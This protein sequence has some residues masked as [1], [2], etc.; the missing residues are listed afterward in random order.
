MLASCALS[1]DWS[2]LYHARDLE[3]ARARLAKDVDLV[4]AQEIQPFLTSAQ[5]H[6]FSK[7][8]LHFPIADKPSPNPLDCYS[9]QDGRIIL[10]LMT[11]AFIEEMA[12]AYS[13][14]WANHYSSETVDEYL[15]M[16]RNREPGDFPDGR[17][18]TPLEA[19]HIP[20][21]AMNNPAV[22]AMTAR[23]R[24]TTLSFLLLH[25]FGHLSYKT[26]EQ[27]SV[28]RRD[29]VEADEE[30]A[31]DF[32]LEV[33]K[34]NSEPPAGLLMLVHGLL[35]LPAEAGK[36]HPLSTMRLRS[37]ADYLDLRV[38]EFAQG[39]PDGR[40]AATAIHSLARHIRHASTFLADT[41]GQR[42]WVEQSRRL[43]VASLT[44]RRIAEQ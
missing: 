10:P 34:K 12:Q 23:V 24:G 7:L 9:P 27:E 25:Q 13:W 19:L 15:G 30:Q 41:T 3:S 33:M 38:R 37:M 18:P 8:D 26:A 20:K 14:L 43:T 44:P 1:A 28:F 17:Y 5:A 32:A 39:R 11:I 36:D 35:Y 31:D 21:D 4:I 42:L 16:L 22:A 6:A 2:S 40:L 29:P